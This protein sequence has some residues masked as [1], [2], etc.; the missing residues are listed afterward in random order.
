MTDDFKLIYQR[1]FAHEFPV[2]IHTRITGW[3]NRR[4]ETTLWQ[5]DSS[6]KHWV[7]LETGRH[8]PFD[9]DRLLTR[10]YNIKA[11]EARLLK[12]G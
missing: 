12:K 9:A 3:I 5:G 4:A 6:G 7:N 11:R 1:Y 2:L 10:I 8:A